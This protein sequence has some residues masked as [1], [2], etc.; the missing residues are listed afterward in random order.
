MSQ[1]DPDEINRLIGEFM[2]LQE[3]WERDRNSF[4]WR[5]LQGLAQKSAHAYNDG[6]GP[7]F[8]AV[9]LDGIEHSEFH[10]RFLTY[11][12][13]EGFDPFKLTGK[14][15]AALPILGHA[16][17]AEAAASNS[18]S[19]RMRAALMDLARARFEPLANEAESGRHPSSSPLFAMLLA[20]VESVPEDLLQRIMPELVKSHGGATVRKTVNPVEGYLSP[21]EVGVEN[22][23]R[24]NG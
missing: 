12:L 1:Q 2:D 15:A 9:A 20:C 18:S 14:G 22:S 11:L 24:P 6:A 13:Q 16:S 23:W 5:A 10:E 19:A 7:S 17:L 3:E 21:A 8:H 4:D